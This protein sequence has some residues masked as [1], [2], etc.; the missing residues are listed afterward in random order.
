MHPNQYKKYIVTK[1]RQFFYNGT[2]F[3][4]L[5]QHEKLVFAADRIG[6]KLV[7]KGP[8]ATLG[9]YIIFELLEDD[10]I[11]ELVNKQNCFFYEDGSRYITAFHRFKTMAT[12]KTSGFENKPNLGVGRF[13]KM[14][15]E[16]Y[17]AKAAAII[18]SKITLFDILEKDLSIKLGRTTPELWESLA[19]PEKPN[20]ASQGAYNTPTL[21][22]NHGR[23]STKNKS[24]D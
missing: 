4:F 10:S 6:E 12:G 13:Q 20:F 9:S 16:R 21:S 2:E 22:R 1:D 8:E 15:N 7:I 18:E 14:K 5:R 3:F 17:E 23:V 19:T 11:P 24:T